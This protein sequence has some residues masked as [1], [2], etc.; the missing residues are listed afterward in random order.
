VN[1]TIGPTRTFR[2]TAAVPGDKSIAHR[3]LLFGALAHGWTR[4]AGIPGG[5]D[6]CATVRALGTCGVH[7]QRN[8]D[9]VIVQGAGRRAFRSNGARIDCGN[10]GTTMRLL[11]GVLA[12]QTG[13]A[14]LVGDASLSRRPMRRVADPLRR[15]GA[16]VELTGGGVAPLRVTGSASLQGT[17]HELPVPSAQLKSALLLAGLGAQGRTRLRGAL[18]SRDHTERMLPLFGACVHASEDEI[19]IEGG[20]DLRGVFLRV[21]GDPS[22]AAF[23]VAAAVMLADAEIEVRG[24]LL[25]PLRLGFVNVLRRMGARIEIDVQ[26]EDPEPVGTIFARTSSLRAA[27]VEAGEVP[28]LIDELPLLALAATQAQGATVVR[29]AAELRVKES[30]RIEAIARVLRAMG[31][32]IETYEDGF[33]VEG[34]QPLRGTA[35][36]SLGDHRIAMTAAIAGL[37]AR[38]GVHVRD[39]QCAGVSFPEFFAQLQSLGANVA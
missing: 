13:T 11:M 26:R 10:S 37:L 28:S 30:D 23:L 29:G 17:D 2:G 32:S 24:V 39:A 21:P 15:M 12:A 5:A 8:G 16:A 6:V 19:S 38:G 20:Q 36:D 34:P 14:E 7:A 33:A 1:V 35:I 18:H 22:S 4:I 27:R 3:A 25:N 31:A 9:G